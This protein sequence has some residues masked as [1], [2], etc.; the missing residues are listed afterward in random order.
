M[1][2]LRTP[3]IERRF[4]A[5]GLAVV[6]VLVVALNLVVFFSVR[7]RANAMADK[8]FLAQE[9]VVTTEAAL[10]SARGLAQRLGELGIDAVVIA[11]D[12]NRLPSNPPEA[13]RQAGE[14]RTSREVDVSRG[15]RVILSTPS[16]AGDPRVGRVLVSAAVVTPLVL[17]FAALLLRLVAEIAT[18][19]LDEIARRARRTTLGLSGERLQ[20]DQPDTRLGHMA[21]AYDDM[22]DTLEGAV[23]EARSA[24]AE[25]E[26]QGLRTRKI[27]ETA[28]DAFLV[29][30]Q[31]G[32]IIDWNPS[33]E[34]MFGWPRDEVVGRR[35]DQALI[36]ADVR[37]G[38]EADRPPGADVQT[39]RAGS[40]ELVAVR[41]DGT[42]F[43]AVLTVWETDH[44]GAC[45]FNAFVHDFTDRQRADDATARLAAAMATAADEA[46][47]SEARTRRFLDDAAHQLR[48]PITSIRACAETLQLD[49][50]PAQHDR[51][52][53]AVCRESERAGRL[54]AGLLRM[55]RLRQELAVEPQPTDVVALCEE[56]ADKASLDSPDLHLEVTT[57]GRPVGRPRLPADAVR[58]ILANLVDNARR[59][60][61][62]RIEI[63]T[64]A[65]DHGL[66]L[67]V[68]DDGPG[69]AADQSESVFERFVSLDDRG[70]SGLGLAIARELA[71]AG[72]GDLT[73]EEHAFVLRLPS[74]PE[75]S[76][77]PGAGRGATMQSA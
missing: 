10:L 54:M 24:R 72:G 36:P 28:N 58:E 61:R 53:Q 70:G 3:S 45:T 23:A 52:L 8:A 68:I 9:S 18:R 1:S 75:P 11:P 37:A 35:W 27:L 76:A 57:V 15:M 42:R 66:E 17:V 60:A 14:A 16:A 59:H 2:T 48:A 44:E 22:L 31:G 41:R 19:P 6:A 43:P 46:R 32:A 50:T 5:V 21:T 13:A 30:D 4:V 33:A 34:Q 62:S 20:P 56:E 51:L 25:S 38:L 39:L 26:R 67:R 69:L 73:Y 49:V 65:R 29:V 7:A 47:E 63:R 40:A 12:G 55:A 74:A 71:R 64:E 77:V